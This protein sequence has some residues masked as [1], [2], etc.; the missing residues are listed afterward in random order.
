LVYF[1]QDCTKFHEHHAN[2]GP[3]LREM[4]QILVTLQRIWS[5]HPKIEPNHIFV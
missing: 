4:N 3:F 5:I 2:V 1:S